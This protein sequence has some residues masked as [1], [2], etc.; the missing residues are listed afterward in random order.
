MDRRDDNA[1]TGG[2]AARSDSVTESGVPGCMFVGAFW[3]V[4]ALAC[5]GAGGDRSKER[6]GA[7][8]CWPAVIIHAV[9]EYA[10]EKL[11]ET[12]KP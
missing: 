3:L 5:W 8:A 1:R 7:C 6:A 4:F 11:V 2:A 9:G 12:A 10:D